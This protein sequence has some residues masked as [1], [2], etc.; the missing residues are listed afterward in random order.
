[1]NTIAITPQGLVTGSNDALVAGAAEL[2]RATVTPR[3]GAHDRM[4]DLVAAVSV[5]WARIPVQQMASA[6]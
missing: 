5:P 1:M 2:L 6:A 4:S 3:T